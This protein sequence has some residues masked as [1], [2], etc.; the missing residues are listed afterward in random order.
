MNVIEFNHIWK[1]F[2]KGER[3]T[4]LRDAIPSL[5]KRLAG[6][7]ISPDTD[8]TFWA[9]RDVSFK[10]RRGEALGIIGPNGAGK[11]TILKLISGIM[12][13]NRGS[14]DVNGKISALIEITAGF[15]PDLTGR[16][17]IYLNGS[18]MGMSRKEINKKFDSIIE[19]SG[20]KDFIDTPVKRYS[21]GM[22]V[23][24]GFSVA[25]HIDP[26]IL[27]ID[28]VLAV[29]DLAF[30]IKCLQRIKELKESKTTIVFVSHSLHSVRNLCQRTLWLDEGQIQ[31]F[32]ESNEVISKYYDYSKGFILKESKERLDKSLISPQE[33]SDIVVTQVD[34]LNENRKTQNMFHPL[35]RMIVKIFYKASKKIECP[36]FG[37]R[38]TNENGLKIGVIQSRWSKEYKDSVARRGGFVEGTG[39]VECVIDAL[40]LLAGY[41]T[42]DVEIGDP[43]DLE[44]YCWM[45]NAATF[46]I[47]ALGLS[48]AFST[49][50]EGLFYLPNRWRCA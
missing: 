8:N 27:L 36:N 10:V 30:R 1:S 29:G 21:S 22:Y 12:R 5:L 48:E 7:R 33:S 35:E 14:I 43:C 45:R 39:C 16:E 4:A 11:T 49:D 37:I 44:K 46:G 17:N 13:S 47:S 50:N 19:F 24:L 2:K 18:I 28:E 42:L 40:N 15:H 41:Y 26:D 6:K 38:L 34:I 9:L 31:E 3:G 23:R 32:G 25:A 20:I